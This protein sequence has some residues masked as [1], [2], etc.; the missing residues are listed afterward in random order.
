VDRKGKIWSLDRT[1]ELA[2]LGGLALFIIMLAALAQ[3]LGWTD[4]FPVWKLAFGILLV[5]LLRG[6]NLATGNSI[7]PA[8][9]NRVV[10]WM[11]YVLIATIAVAVIGFMTWLAVG[12]LIGTIEA[13]GKAVL[14]GL[15][16]TSLTA[17]VIVAIGSEGGEMGRGRRIVT[18][19]VV[20]FGVAF[21]VLLFGY[22]ALEFVMNTGSEISNELHHVLGPDVTLSGLFYLLRAGT[23]TAIYVAASIAPAVIFGAVAGRSEHERLWT[24]LALIAALLAGIVIFEG[25]GHLYL[26]MQRSFFG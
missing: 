11:A 14:I 1:E 13:H 16:L 8:N 6:I 18:T 10:T 2:T 9:V 22:L 12:G 21:V 19:T 5:L 24:A 23:A 15:I 17:A 20:W 25:V 3:R 7:L 4:G 26:E